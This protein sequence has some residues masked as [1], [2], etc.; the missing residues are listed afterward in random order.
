M[1]QG[2]SPDNIEEFVKNKKAASKILRQEKREAEKGLIQKIEEHRVNP[3]LFFKKCRSIKEGFK[4]QT[5][6][7]KDNDGNLIT[8]EEGII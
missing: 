1:I 3:R 6:M 2:P 8:N 7:V 4:A 5:R